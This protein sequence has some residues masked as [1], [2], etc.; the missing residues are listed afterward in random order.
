MPQLESSRPEL[1]SK[2]LGARLQVAVGRRRASELPV[3]GASPHWNPWPNVTERTPG[4]PFRFLH[5]LVRT[6]ASASRGSDRSRSSGSRTSRSPGWYLAPGRVEHEPSELAG[7][8]VDVRA[9]VLLVGDD[10]SAVATSSSGRSQCRSSRT[11]IVVS[12]LRRSAA[13]PHD[14]PSRNPRSPS[15]AIA[16]CEREENCRPRAGGFEGP[17]SSS[18]RSSSYAGRVVRPAGIAPARISPGSYRCTA[19]RRRPPRTAIERSF[20]R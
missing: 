5:A 8:V 9:G 7:A 15:A 17:A 19:W 1:L 6:S 18:S 20:R 2:R 4:Q 13:A 12:D 14:D 16:P 11:P 3:A 10:T